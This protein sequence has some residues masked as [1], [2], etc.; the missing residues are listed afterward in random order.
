MNNDVLYCFVIF[1]AVFFFLDIY[2]YSKSNQ[3]IA[4]KN[5]YTSFCG[6][7]VI[8]M[9]YLVLNS[10][11]SLQEYSV[12]HLPRPMLQALVTCSLCSVVWS[13]Y[14]FF[15]YTAEKTVFFA[16]RTRLGRVLCRLPALVTTALIVASPWTRWVY[17]FSDSN[18]MIH[19]SLYPAMLV[20]ASLYLLAVMAIAAWKLTMARTT[21]ERQSSLS[22]LV[23]VMIIV[24]FVILDNM[25]DHASI[26][27]VAVH[28]VILVI[29]ISMQE[30][31][32]NSDALTGMNN[33]RKADEYLTG[34][35]L[36]VSRE[37]PLYLFMGD[38]DGFKGINDV[39]GHIEGDEALILCS[40]ALKQ[41]AARSN[42]FVA[43]FGGDEFLISCQP[44]RGAAFDPEALIRSVNTLLEQ[45]TLA[46]NKP[47]AL[48][49]S[50]GYTRCENREETLSACIHRADEALYQRKAARKPLL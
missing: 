38:L 24:V 16:L 31:N 20:L 27:P 12:L 11:W 32:I 39:H 26:L 17:S 40:Q 44:G 35:L 15:H 3:G 2:M 41:V 18:Q 29:F 1:Q 42:A 4:R 10:T 25:F 22:L 48:T 46:M 50:I 14:T 23:S 21:A 37:N 8:H 34:R 33:R 13:S 5:E 30:S 6:L 7:I 9:L 45:K 36:E 49:M 28:A 19:E 43:R 47:Y